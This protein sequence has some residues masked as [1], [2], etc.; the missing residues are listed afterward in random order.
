MK[1][2]FIEPAYLESKDAIDYY[3]QEI[4]N[5]GD[6]FYQELISTITLI[7]KFPQIWSKNSEHTQKRLALREYPSSANFRLTPP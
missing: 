5:L 2:S 3:N 7:E 6:K 1:I 4:S